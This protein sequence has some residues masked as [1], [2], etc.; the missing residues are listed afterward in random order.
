MPSAS[1][2][3]PERVLLTVEQAALR[4]SISRTKMFQLI[5]YGEVRSVRIGRS[6]RVPA[7]ALTT[8]IE[9]LV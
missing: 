1:T 2:N 7:D 8:Y 9:R 6:R 4:L 3:A 5:K